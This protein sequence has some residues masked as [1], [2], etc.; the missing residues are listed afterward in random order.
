[1][2]TMK[3]E[4]LTKK[5]KKQKPTLQMMRIHEHIIFVKIY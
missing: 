1:M 2:D 5:K 3:N 4:N